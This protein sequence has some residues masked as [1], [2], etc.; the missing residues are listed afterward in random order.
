MDEMILK[1]LKIIDDLQQDLN[2]LKETYEGILEDDPAYQDVLESEEK[3]KEETKQQRETVL[4]KDAYSEIREQIKEKRQE[5]KE[6]KEAL[7]QELV[8]YYK[9]SGSLEIEDHNGNVKHMK[10]SVRLIN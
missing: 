10:F 2:G 4:A 6:H 1:R 8:E 5:V 3:I 9:Q 7:A